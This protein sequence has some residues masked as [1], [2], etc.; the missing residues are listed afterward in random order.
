MLALTEWCASRFIETEIVVS[1]TLQRH[2]LPLDMA[3][4]WNFSREEGEKW[5]RRNAVALQGHTIA[6]WDE[7]LQHPDYPPCMQ[8]IE[9]GLADRDAQKSLT[10]MA[11]QFSNRRNVP[12]EKCTAFL[13]EELAVFH[14]MMQEPAVDIYAGSWITALFD[15]LSLATFESLHCLEVDFERKKS[16]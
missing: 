15:T 6:R 3:A 12:L 9:D 5:L 13:K 8:A 16:A 2:N 4:A 11:E 7:L 14:F 10:S 1:D